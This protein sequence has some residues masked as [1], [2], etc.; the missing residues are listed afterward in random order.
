M[1]FR[2]TPDSLYDSYSRVIIKTHH[3]K[4]QSDVSKRSSNE[5]HP[6][7]IIIVNIVFRTLDAVVA[8]SKNSVPK[9]GLFAVVVALSPALAVVDIVVFDD[10]LCIENPQQPG[11]CRGW[12]GVEAKTTVSSEL[13][14]HD[15]LV[16]DPPV[17]EAHGQTH[18]LEG[19]VGH[20]RNASN[21][22]EFLFMVRVEGKQW[23]GVLGE[24][25]GAVVLPETANV[26]HQT[27]V[28]VEPEVQNDA[29]EADFEGQPEPTD[30]VG[31][32]ARS[33]AEE[34]GHHRTDSGS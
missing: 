23:V 29:V 25:V 15:I 18:E 5:G 26:M 11:E 4:N 28:P 6:N 21:V 30:C 32:L 33:V 14:K 9:T 27:V 13:G 19:E 2:R 7:G 1:P 34:D 10:Q 3:G 24:M 17:V 20:Q 22:E 8:S 16:A 31:R 12:C